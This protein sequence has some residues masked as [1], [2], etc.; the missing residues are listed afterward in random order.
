VPYDISIDSWKQSCCEGCGRDECVNQKT[1][2][3]EE[4]LPEA[5]IVLKINVCGRVLVSVAEFPL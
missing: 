5:E 3:A 2:E 1:E 4:E